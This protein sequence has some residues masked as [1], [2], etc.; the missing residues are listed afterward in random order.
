[1]L[2]VRAGIGLRHPHHREFLER[3]P[4]IGFVEVHSENFFGDGGRD[5]DVLGR[6]RADHAVSLHGVGLSLGRA[7]GVDP[8]HLQRLARLVARIEPAV[9][10]DH[11]CWGA[12]GDAHWNDLL[13]LPMTP[14]ALDVVATAVSRVQ[15]TLRRP[16]LV[17]NVSAYVQP[18]LADAMPEAEFVAQ[19]VARTGCGLL[20]D[21][22]NVYVNALNHGFD[23]QTA[24]DAMPAVAVRELHL[25]GHF[26]GP[27]CVIDHHGDRVC[28]A[29]WAL[30]ARFVAQHGARPTLIEW[31]TD[32]P[33]LDVLLEEAAHAQRIL[34]RT[35][36]SVDA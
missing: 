5:L 15:D 19:L 2:P 20:L 32:L 13:P 18:D 4:P 11:L 23:A 34:D 33:T 1:M 6:V 30:H 31:D 12:I 27:D 17:E 22:N 3:Q 21:L 28:D 8:A 7:D 25:A 9:V 36:E 29:V 16:I 10:S 35:R 24:I 14:A 26:V